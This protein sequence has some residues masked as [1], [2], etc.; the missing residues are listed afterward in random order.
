TSRLLYFWD[1]ITPF[2]DKGV[3]APGPLLYPNKAPVG[4]LYARADLTRE[5]R[6]SERRI[7]E[8]DGDGHG[9]ACAAIAAANG[10]RSGKEY[11]GVAA[12]VDLVA[13][14]IG[15]VGKMEH[16]FLLGAVCTWL[17]SVAGD[18]P[19]VVTCSFGGHYSGHDGCTILERELNARFAPSRAGR[20][21]CIA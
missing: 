18:R 14:R 17:E 21:I 7:P 10:Q 6:A 3:G 5:L 4:V 15:S 2:E 1:T 9:T 20:A 19:L 13:V 11:A 8:L 16:A 12:V